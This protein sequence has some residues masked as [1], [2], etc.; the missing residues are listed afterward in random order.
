MA[1]T[2]LNMSQVKQILQLHR[3]NK[4]RKTIARCL[5][6][7]KATVKSY[8]DK[9]AGIKQSIDALLKLEDNEL[10]KLFFSG[11]PA[12]KDDRFEVLNKLLDSYLRELKKTGVT[13][14][15][16]WEEYRQQ[17]PDGYGRSQF[18]YHI[19][20]HLKK[21]NPSLPLSHEPGD[22]LFVDFAGKKL[23]YVDMETGEIIECQVFVACLPY[24]DYCFC[25]AVPS[26][27]ID[28]FIY[29]LKMCLEDL[30]GVPKAL[31]PDNLKAAVTKA[32][33]YEPEI[34]R[35]L[36][37]FANHYN[38]AVVPARARKPQDKALVENQ[39]KLIYS[40]VYARIRDMQFHSIGELNEA[41]SEHTRKHNQTRM[42]KRDYCREEHFLSNEKHLLKPL[43]KNEFEIKYYKEYTLAQN[44]HILLGQDGHYY[45]APYK[46]IGKKLKVIYTR[47]LVRIFYNREQIAVH[48][49]DYRKNVYTTNK[50]HL[51]STH[52]HYLKRS[53]EYYKRKAG[54]L[55]ESFSRFVE[56]M[57]EQ[58][59]YP[60]QLYRSCDGLL[61]LQRNTDNLVFDKA[62]RIA[63]EHE[64][65]KC[66]FVKNIIQNKMTSI[67]IEE[68]KS[69][70][71]K[72]NN[73]RGK[74]YYNNQLS[75]KF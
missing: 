43:P 58:D 27:T 23:S 72:H 19:A 47:S 29:A 15:V 59:V 38:M 44:N 20:Q 24:S 21:K 35:T 67:K 40:R 28:D 64:N 13:R 48:K 17:Y 60:E 11:N 12:Y 36:Q 61:S 62:C 75:L 54:E 70:L 52:L 66:G 3:Q 63:I 68:P 71:P 10:E 39:V 51:C 6:I 45:S 65:Y 2:P 30:S 34:N 33:K 25:I 53:P 7:S 42:Q 49:R 22:K 41:I 37:D 5:K 16:L 73:I 57:F 50:D 69:S 8:L 26:Q 1:G 55:S 9:L 18:S 32:D 31:V 46:Y 14:Q 4:G 74:E 56:L